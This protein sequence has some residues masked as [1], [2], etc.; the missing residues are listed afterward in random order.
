MAW[1][2]EKKPLP[3]SIGLKALKKIGNPETRRTTM[4]TWP[5]GV[6]MS[7]HRKIGGGILKSGPISQDQDRC[8]AF[9]H[10]TQSCTENPICSRCSGPYLYLKCPNKEETPKCTNCQ[11]SHSAAYRKCEKYIE[12][13]QIIKEKIEARVLYSEMVKKSS[14]NCRGSTPIPG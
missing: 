12:T 8:Q 2:R 6:E 3:K 5:Q 1:K 7:T 10:P 11:Q 9:S 13:K 14:E 4:V